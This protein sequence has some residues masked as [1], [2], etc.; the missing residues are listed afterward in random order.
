MEMWAKVIKNLAEIMADKRDMGK[1]TEVEFSENIIKW[2]KIDQNYKENNN[3]Y[4]KF[5]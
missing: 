3:K 4:L 5:S 1:L 2:N